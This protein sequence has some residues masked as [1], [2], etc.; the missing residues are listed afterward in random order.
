MTDGYDGSEAGALEM[1]SVGSASLSK[2][3]RGWRQQSVS[4]GGALTDQ[5]GEGQE[6]EEP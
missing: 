6:D 4:S 1:A 2:F 5:N 3:E